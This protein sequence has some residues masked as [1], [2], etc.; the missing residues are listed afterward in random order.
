[1]IILIRREE[2]T[3]ME[4]RAEKAAKKERKVLQKKGGLGKEYAAK[5]NVRKNKGRKR[6]DFK[7]K[8]SILYS[9]TVSICKKIYMLLFLLLN[10]KQNFSNS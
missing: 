10:Y 2:P 7:N 3:E 1:M 4:V 9:T 6:W 5:K 8:I